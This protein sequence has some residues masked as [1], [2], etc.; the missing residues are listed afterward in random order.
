MAGAPI[1][2]EIAI[3]RPP[4][5]VWERTQDPELHARWDARFSRIDYR[6]GDGDAQRFVYERSLLPGLVVRGWGETRGE[7]ASADQAGA[8]ALA[9]GSDQKRSLIRHGSGYWRYV[10]TE[11]GTRFLTPYDYEP[12]WGPLG[13]LV[14]RL[15]FRP[16]IGWAT[17]WSFD[18]LRLWLED[19][20]PPEHALRTALLHAAATWS[21]AAAWLYQGIVPKLLVRDSGELEILRRARVLPGHEERLLAAVG[22]AEVALAAAI[23]AR[24][25]RRWP[26]LVNLAVLPALAAG[27]VR[28]D[29][30]LFV[31]PFNP[32]SLSFAMLG[33]G[34]VGVLARH[35]R[36]TARRCRRAP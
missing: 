4:A 14:D 22:A 15:A 10:P 18:R 20:V 19:G 9:F 30:S 13:R 1:Y 23:L 28:S 16:L 25:H 12:R 35:G 11:D 31:R 36:P 21:L 6:P 2:V 26:W 7:R 32:A 5:D 24:G 27:A 8:S 17:A 3:A 33:L 34:A 29:R